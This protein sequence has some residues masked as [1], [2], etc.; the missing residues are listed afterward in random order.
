MAGPQNVVYVVTDNGANYKTDG[1]KIAEKYSNIYW[2]PCAAHC[3][4][5]IMKDIVEMPT[6][7]SL[8]VLSPK[9]T[10]F[11]YNHKWVL[12]WLRKQPKWT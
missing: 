12:N 7:E 1:K 9:F 3:I 4:N 6:V 11:I 5:L 2:S 8:I 10:V